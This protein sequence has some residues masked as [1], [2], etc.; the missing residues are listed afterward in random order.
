M[1]TYT[2]SVMS[3]YVDIIAYRCHKPYTGVT[4]LLGNVAPTTNA[5]RPALYA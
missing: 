3:N 4:D 5:V 1:A 2:L